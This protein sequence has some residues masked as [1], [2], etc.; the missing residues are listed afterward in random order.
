MFMFL[1]KLGAIE[2][3]KPVYPNFKQELHISKEELKATITQPIVIGIDFGLTPAAVFG[4]RTALG[5][6]NILN[7]LVCFD[8]G[9]MRFSELLRG[10]IAKNYKNF[11]IQIYGD[12]A[13]DFRSQTDERTPFSI[14]RNYG[15]KALPAP[16]NDVALR[17][18]SVDTALQRLIDGKAGFMIDPKCINLKKRI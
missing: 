10:E 12:P 15:L 16:S 17:I 7:E 14:M 13:G 18:E 4:Q 11:D 3:G 9:V 8:M 1:N 5:R 2:E 6:W